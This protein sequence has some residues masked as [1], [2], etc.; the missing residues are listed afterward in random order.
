MRL[1][2]LLEGWA[3]ITD[4]DERVI[5]GITLDSRRV[6]PGNCFF[7]LGSA[8]TRPA[9]H[10]VEAVALGAAAVV[11]D[12]ASN[13]DAEVSI[14]IVRIPELKGK[15]GPIAAGYFGQPSESLA[16]MA[17]TGTNGKTTVAHSCAQALSRCGR[18]CGYLGTLGAGPLGALAPTGMTTPD[19]IT[20]QRTLATMLAH[21]CD[22]VAMEASSHA[23]AQCRLAG[24]Q[25]DVGVF[26]GLGHDHLD[27]HRNLA[28]YADVKR[29]LFELPGLAHA[30]LN[31]DDPQSSNYLKT[32]SPQ[33]EVWQY[34]LRTA[35]ELNA[36]TQY[37]AVR[38][39]QYRADGTTLDVESSAGNFV[40][41]TRLV[42]DFNAQNLLAIL[43]I[44]LA[45]EIPLAAACVAVES[46]VPVCG[47]LEVFGGCAGQ[48]LVYVDYAHSPDSL[49][50]VLR[51]L[52]SFNPMQLIC[53]FG[54]GGERDRSKRPLMGAVAAR[55]A[56]QVII[57]ADNPRG[58]DQ[59]MIAAQILKGIAD[60]DKVSV[61]AD[62]T[63][64]IAQALAIATAQDIVLIAGKGHETFQEI[65]GIRFP[66]SDQAIVSRLLTALA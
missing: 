4:R 65:G 28:A 3:A 53:V 40:L 64:A 21:G 61:V 11:M 41:T 20:L 5:S 52:R 35:R 2:A 62:R 13:L 54:C 27:Y 33:L 58:E 43:G 60:S 12:D 39:A 42:G 22:S 26:T 57:T 45:F 9:Q 10:I 6:L 63:S 7:A 55:Y 14:P 36:T 50:R 66:L 25:V 51:L 47:R 8:A 17:V 59:T 37:L 31:A 29:K 49:E 44:L 23:L 16:V 46:V 34:S 18:H 48:P 38:Q 19:P 24:M 56:D 1:S 30:I 15:V 32:F